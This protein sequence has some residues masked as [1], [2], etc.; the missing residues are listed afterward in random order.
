MVLREGIWGFHNVVV[1]IIVVVVVVVVVVVMVVPEY[2]Y[3]RTC[4]AFQDGLVVYEIVQNLPGKRTK[5]V[6]TKPTL[7]KSVNI[8]NYMNT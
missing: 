1:F 4:V 8:N 7:T 3:I 6:I 5:H 2:Y